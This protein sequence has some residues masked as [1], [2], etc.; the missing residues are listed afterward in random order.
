MASVPGILPS[1]TGWAPGAGLGLVDR[2]G[3][4][5]Q[6]RALEPGNG[7]GRPGAVGHRDK[8]KALG[9]A[10]V[11]IRNDPA[12]VDHA[13]GRKELVQVIGGGGER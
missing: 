10:S 8:A 11:T 12:L 2:E 5:R 7:G 1:G 9:A 4:A 3:T 13:I 6:L